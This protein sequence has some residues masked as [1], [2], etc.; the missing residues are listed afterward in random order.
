MKIHQIFFNNSLRNFSYLISF[1]DG[2]IFCIDPLNPKE[3][4]STLNDQQLAGIINTH[5]HCDHYSGNEELAAAFQ[6]PVM[7]HPKAVVPAKNKNLDDQEIIHQLISEDSQWCLKSIFTPGHT[8]SHLCVLLEKNNS[9]YALFTGDCFFNAGVGNC[10]NGGDPE[11]L[12][13]TISTIFKNLPD[14]TL[15]Y[16][17]HEYIMRNLEF[18]INYEPRNSNALEFL[19]KIKKLNLNET[20]FINNMKTEREINTF[21]RLSSKNLTD[22]L[23]LKNSNEKKIFLTLRELRNSW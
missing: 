1:N 4:L 19:K 16:P 3:V 7:A 22:S 11:I 17:G 12:Y 9:P 23:K 20:F 6:C 18:T 15:I 13:Q 5:D 2:A 21:L 14:E 10:H 8:L